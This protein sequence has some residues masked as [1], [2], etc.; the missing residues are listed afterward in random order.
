ML[1]D[2]QVSLKVF[3]ISGREITTLF[4]GRKSAGTH[5]EKWKGYDSDKQGVSS[6]IYFYQ[7][8]AGENQ[9]TKK[10]IFAK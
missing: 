6:G 1:N 9:V 2:E 8:R 10:M 7:L 5:F 4:E 3:D